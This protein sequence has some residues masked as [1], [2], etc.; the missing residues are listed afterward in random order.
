MRYELLVASRYLRSRR[1]SA[2]I[3]I[4]TFF[5]AI[6]VM[7]GVAALTITVA[8]MNGFEANLR[9]RI[10]SLTPQVQVVRYGAMSN[11]AEVAAD[12][13]KIR[14]VTGADPYIIGQG[15]LT[16]KTAAR[17]VVVRGI[18]PSNPAA[19]TDL[20]RYLEH[21]SVASLNAPTASPPGASNGAQPPL[22]AIAVGS[23]L[24][25]KLHVHVGDE[26]R[27]IS[28]ISL[29]GGEINATSAPFRIG[30]TFLSG[31]QFIDETVI[32]MELHRAQV[33][34]GRKQQ[35]DGVQV[36]LANLDDTWRVTDEL[37]KI[38]SFPPYRV[39]NWIEINQAASAGFAML[40]RVY[41]L[42]LMMLIAVAAFNL[43]AML[44]MVV[45]EKRKDIA[46]LMT[47]GATRGAV[48]LIFIIKGLIVGAVG[49]IAGVILGITGCFTLAHYHFIHIPR[50]IYG[51]STLPVAASPAA[52]AW[53]ALA[54][55]VLCFVAALYPARQASK[56]LPVEVIR[57]E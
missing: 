56:Q 24:A 47:M 45:M 17:G 22:A 37:R 7:I 32:F 41:S 51:I 19:L 31:V 39:R 12:A 46:I 20:R 40:K 28:P 10:L 4:T 11:Y 14:G 43:V 25:D 16:S 48:R 52:F 1:K 21:G 5:T 57:W 13:M 55:M 2:F 6:G 9:T 3:S 44:I 8:V 38:F 49:T 27:L 26:V 42:V 36:H 23:V 34:F 15:M 54:A 53:V 30:A 29:A 18:D 33:F 50:E 35:V